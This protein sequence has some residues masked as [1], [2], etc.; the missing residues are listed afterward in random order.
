VF[1]DDFTLADPGREPQHEPDAS[2]GIQASPASAG[3]T[4]S[5]VAEDATHGPNR[6]F[7]VGDQT[8]I[9]TRRRRGFENKWIDD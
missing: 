1:D 6:L 8:I 4:E 2:N 5:I 9:G 7:E 3:V